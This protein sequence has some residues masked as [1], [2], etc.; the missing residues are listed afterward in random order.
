MRSEN[1]L[2]LQLIQPYS[3]GVPLLDDSREKQRALRIPIWRRRPRPS[4]SIRPVEAP[5]P[6]VE[7]YAGLDMMRPE[8]T[9]R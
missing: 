1:I 3:R 9:G 4:R 2:A 6:I 7:H 5:Q 8:Y